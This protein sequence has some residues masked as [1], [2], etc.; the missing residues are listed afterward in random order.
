M[1]LPIPASLLKPLLDQALAL[2]ADKAGKGNPLVGTIL[3]AG[4]S[5]VDEHGSKPP[6]EL[7]QAKQQISAKLA[8]NFKGMGEAFERAR[9][10]GAYKGP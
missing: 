8:A 4:R 6:P 5:L 2:A 7:A 1:N 9:K 3:A 10:A